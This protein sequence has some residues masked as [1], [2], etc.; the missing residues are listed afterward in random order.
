MLSNAVNTKTPETEVPECK[1]NEPG[2][3]NYFTATPA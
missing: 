1:I 3:N 2:V